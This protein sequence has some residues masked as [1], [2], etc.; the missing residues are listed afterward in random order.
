MDDL[1]SVVGISAP[2]LRLKIK[3][4]QN[5]T[6]EFMRVFEHNFSIRYAKQF[7]FQKVKTKLNNGMAKAFNLTVGCFFVCE[8]LK[9][10]G[11]HYMQSNMNHTSDVLLII[12]CS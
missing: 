3:Q 8:D 6:T 2:I 11:K 9:E 1:G 4:S 10:R 7:N 5:F 12:E